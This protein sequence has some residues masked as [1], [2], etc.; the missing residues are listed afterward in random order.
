MLVIAVFLVLGIT[1]VSAET[2]AAHVDF[3]LEVRPI[4]SDNCFQCHGPDSSTR[5]ANL[6][7]DTRE[8]AFTH[9]DNGVPVVPGDPDASLIMKRLTH[10]QEALRMPPAHSRKS[11]TED[12]IGVIRNWIGQGADWSGHWA[13]R[14][15]ESTE[16]P[17]VKN[18]SWVHNPV[19]QFILARLEAEGLTPA[20]E[21]DKRTLARRVA[22][23]L[24][25]LPPEPSVVEQFVQ[26]KSPEA[27]NNLIEHYLTS[28][29]YGEHRARYWLDAARYADTHGIHFD[30]YRQM[31]P[32][33]DWVIK[34][35]NRNLPFDQFTVHQ[36]AGDMLPDPTLDQLI[37][38]GFHRCNATTNEGGVIPEEYEAIYAKDRVDTTGTVFLGL[39]V[40]CASCHDHKFDPILQ[41]DFYSMAA[42]FRN[43]TQHA[44]DGNISDSPPTLVVPSDEDRDQWHQLR[45]EATELDVLIK[46]AERSSQEDFQQ[47]YLCRRPRR[48]TVRLRSGYP[49][50]Q[51]RRKG[52]AGRRGVSK[53]KT[54]NLVLATARAGQPSR[55]RRRGVQFCCRSL[56]RLHHERHHR[57]TG[58]SRGLGPSENARRRR[59]RRLLSRIRRSEKILPA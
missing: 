1:S 18:K 38:T 34:A 52:R 53:K 27:Y 40:G 20:P 12:Q 15:P 2:T 16:L 29:A 46:K 32:Y 26:D 37:A 19:D 44:M 23:D 24:T 30:N 14:A 11:L 31:W 56:N 5:L 7:L 21:A 41:K 33:R 3:Q 8:G 35:Y 42:F 45:A 50:D 48:H 55:L 17:A 22:L 13:F 36:I 51:G 39:T 49:M 58:R 43:T 54:A 59:Q 28:E 9:R 10:E 4:L 6:R 57:C 25:G 47:R